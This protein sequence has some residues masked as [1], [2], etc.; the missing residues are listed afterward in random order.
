MNIESAP[1]NTIPKIMHWDG[2]GSRPGQQACAI[3]LFFSSGFFPD[4]SFPKM[5]DCPGQS[6]WGSVDVTCAAALLCTHTKAI[7]NYLGPSGVQALLLDRWWAW[8]IS[9]WSDGVK[10]FLHHAACGCY[11]FISACNCLKIA[12]VQIN[13]M[14]CSGHS[15]MGGWMWQSI[16]LSFDSKVC[17]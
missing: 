16:M 6:T 4:W 13:R 2:L 1:L 9:G 3:Q 12:S 14:K 7:K 11:F 8:S 5:H 17:P 10:G 15:Y